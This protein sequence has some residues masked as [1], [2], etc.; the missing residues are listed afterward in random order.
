MKPF[1]HGRRSLILTFVL[2]TSIRLLSSSPGMGAEEPLLL[3]RQKAIPS[4]ALSRNDYLLALQRNLDWFQKSGM[5]PGSYGSGGVV[6]RIVLVRDNPQIGDIEK[7]FKG[8]RRQGPYL[9]SEMIRP[10]G[11]FQTAL[12]FYYASRLFN[13]PQAE[14]VSRNIF[15]YLRKSDMQ[16]LDPSSPA[17]GLWTW[18]STVEK[19][20]WSDDNPW[21]TIISLKIYLLT[22]DRDWL[23]KGLLTARGLLRYQHLSGDPAGGLQGR[24]HWGGMRAMGLAF[25]YGLTKDPEFKKAALDYLHTDYKGLILDAGGKPTK[26]PYTTSESSYFLLESSLIAAATH[27]PIAIEC[28][29]LFGDYLLSRRD[30]SGVVPGEARWGGAGDH[31]A[32][33]VYTQNW[34]TLAMWHAYLV[35]KD[36]RYEKSFLQSLNF[37][38]AIQDKGPEPQTKGCWRGAFDALMWEWGGTNQLEGGPGSIYTGWTN[39]PI[40]LAIEFYLNGDSLLPPTLAP[41]QEKQVEV[42][43]DSIKAEAR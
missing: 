2:M 36:Q 22:G 34:F 17:Y 24:P 26:R 28:V 8:L 21:N 33:L 12:T 38:L 14:Q 30:A 9:Y 37:L 7:S 31:I 41:Q 23:H 32:D 27:D 15:D 18:S 1:L 16:V 10:D 43:W 3:G 11:S 5:L 13:S 6:E 4:T 40:D 42:A 39:A 19:T 35:T 29:K 25:A 20:Y